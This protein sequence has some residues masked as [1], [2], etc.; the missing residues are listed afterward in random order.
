MALKVLLKCSDEY[1]GNT[2]GEEYDEY[3]LLEGEAEEAYRRALLL[4]TPLEKEEALRKIL[5]DTE[6]RLKEEDGEEE[7][8]V[9]ARY[10]QPVYSLLKEEDAVT[11]LKKMLDRSDGD[12]SEARGLIERYRGEY[13]GGDLGELAE[14]IAEELGLDDYDPEY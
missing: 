8:R 13:E 12:Y 7:Y 3:V 14:D 10:E 6:E 5:R 4:K 2:I 9:H 1:D 11:L